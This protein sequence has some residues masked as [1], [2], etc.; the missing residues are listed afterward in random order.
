[1]NEME[2]KKKSSDIQNLSENAV[3]QNRSD[4]EDVLEMLK[5]IK[6]HKT[7]M[8]VI[9]KTIIAMFFFIFATSNSNCS[10]VFCLR[11]ILL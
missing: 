5:T 1:M 6:K 7:M 11:H 8:A 3:V 4:L 9:S 2:I 10:L